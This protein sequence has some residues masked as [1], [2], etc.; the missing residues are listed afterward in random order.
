MAKGKRG[1][2]QSRLSQ[3][4]KDKAKVSYNDDQD[5]EWEKEEA[6]ESLQKEEGKCVLCRD[7]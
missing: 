6:A 5:E 7:V 2:K 1:D 3:R 4:L